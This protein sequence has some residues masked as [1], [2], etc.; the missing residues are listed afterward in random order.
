MLSLKTI[1]ST[2]VFHTV[3]IIS[4]TLVKLLTEGCVHFIR[5]QYRFHCKDNFLQLQYEEKNLS[6]QLKLW[7]EAVSIARNKCYSLN[8]FT[9]KQLLLLRKELARKYY[10]DEEYRDVL[11]LQ[12]IT[13]LK[14]LYPCTEAK[15]L[16]STVKNTWDSL[17]EPVDAIEQPQEN[18]N[19][20]TVAEIF[21]PPPE[22]GL[23][24]PEIVET[25]LTPTE[26]FVYTKLTK[27]RGYNSTR[28]IAELLQFRVSNHGKTDEHIIDEISDNILEK[29]VNDE[30]PSEQELVDIINKHLEG[31]AQLLFEHPEDVSILPNEIELEQIKDDNRS[32]LSDVSSNLT[33]VADM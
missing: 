32:L 20:I 22:N 19:D 8:S 24:C 6:R 18:K 28:I 23:T 33:T 17:E 16:V 25:V 14:C 15:V 1:Q 4:D 29:D 11:H 3:L 30:D 27:A 10:H 9:M 7:E 26:R 12:A 13:L 2:K 21:S 5:W 31:K